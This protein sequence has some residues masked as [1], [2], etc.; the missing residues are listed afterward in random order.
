M[1]SLQAKNIPAT[2]RRAKN[3]AH[4]ANDVEFAFEIG[5]GL[6]TEVR[7]LQ[8]MLGERDETI[9]DLKGEI[10]N[11]NTTM[12]AL[13]ETVLSLEQS[14]D[15]YKE[16]NWSLEI[17]IQDL[18]TQLSD[19]QAT[20]Q[21]LESEQK[22]LIKALDTTRE[23]VALREE[24]DAAVAILRDVFNVSTADLPSNPSLGRV[25]DFAA[26]AHRELVARQEED[27]RHAT[28]LQKHNIALEGALDALKKAQEELVAKYE[29]EV[30]LAKKDV[31]ALQREKATLRR[32]LGVIR[33]EMEKLDSQLEESDLKRIE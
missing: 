26:K 32:S 21:K 16:E 27:S 9:E 12:E 14:T 3:A 7:R 10:R 23:S 5:S 18:R 1:S 30:S 11:S 13:R 25:A 15:K 24:T 17:T 29:A 6:L 2:S 28:S 19:Q 31:A 22:R 8:T 4:R 20:S 33:M